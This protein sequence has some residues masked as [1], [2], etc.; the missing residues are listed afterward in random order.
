MRNSPNKAIPL[1][2]TFFFGIV[3]LYFV[4]E[5]CKCRPFPA[6]FCAIFCIIMPRPVLARAA[7]IILYT[8]PC[9]SKENFQSGILLNLNTIEP[10]VSVKKTVSGRLQESNRRR[11]FTRRS[12]DTSTFWRECILCNF[13]VTKENSTINQ[14]NLAKLSLFLNR[15]Y[16]SDEFRENTTIIS[17]SKR[18]AGWLASSDFWKTP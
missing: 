15:V 17:F 6:I 10:P 4:Q 2:E 11:S 16:G 13:L 12:G 14:D 7:W 9:W 3:V 8:L 1:R 18:R 5:I